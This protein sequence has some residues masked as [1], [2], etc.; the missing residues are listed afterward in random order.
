[1]I[2]LR[3]YWV[4]GRRE[5][6]AP[7]CKQR[8]RLHRTSRGCRTSNSPLMQQVSSSQLSL[9]HHQPQRKSDICR[10]ICS[11]RLPLSNE[12]SLAANGVDTDVP[13]KFG[14]L[15]HQ[16]RIETWRLSMNQPNNTFDWL[17]FSGKSSRMRRW[18]EYSKRWNDGNTFSAISTDM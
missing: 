13:R 8:E 2:L 5:L 11:A 9:K 1:M 3:L 10:R 18:E 16:K 17:A 15:T 14:L 4:F 12:H 6:V 7:P